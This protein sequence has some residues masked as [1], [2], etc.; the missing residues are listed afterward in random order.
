MVRGLLKGLSGGAAHAEPE[1]LPAPVVSSV[2]AASRLAILDDF[3]QAGIGWIWASDATGRLIY[4]SQSAADKLGRPPDPLLGQPLVA[5]FETDP[6]NT[7]SERP[8][9]FQLSARN[10]LV[11]LVV[12][13]A[14]QGDDRP[15]W[16]SI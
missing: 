8:L 10:K 13:F 3:E 11:D 5:L 1:P 4:I 7:E 12:R 16:W 2:D 15:L 9:N 6:D 14:G